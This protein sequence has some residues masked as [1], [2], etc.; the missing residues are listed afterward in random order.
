MP[1]RYEIVQDAEMTKPYLT[2]LNQEESD[3]EK[4]AFISDTIKDTSYASSFSLM[5]RIF[6]SKYLNEIAAQHSPS[7]IA[8]HRESAQKIG[9]IHSRLSPPAEIKTLQDIKHLIFNHEFYRLLMVLAWLL[10]GGL[11]EIF[12]AQLGDMRYFAMPATSK[13]PLIDLLHDVF[14]RV[15]NFQIVNYLLTCCVAY[16]VIGFA[17]QSPDWSTRF[18]LIRRYTFILG[19]L[20][21]FRGITLLV[22][23]LPSSLVDECKPP[24]T[25]ITGSVGERFGF[26]YKVVAGSAFGCTDNIFSGHTSVMMSCVLLWRAHSRLRRPFS[27]LLYLIAF[28][29]MLMIIV[30]RFHYTI[31]VLLAIFITY[32]TWNIYLQYIREA[33]TRYIFGF[34]KHAAFDVFNTM[35]V[36]GAQTY[37]YLAWQPHALGQDWLMHLCMYVD[38][39]DIKLRTIGVLDEQG[40]WRP[41]MNQ[42]SLTKSI[43]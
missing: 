27:W 25:E 41:M 26:I 7:A 32:T 40:E 33:S 31:D 6:Y 16:T 8:Q 39:L 21:I 22:T 13:H 12:L 34:T 15:E 35:M 10:L 30:S 36:D 9:W 42:P 1:Q 24:E 19:C 37:Q 18:T 20:Y 4:H 11:I 38:G 5:H 28:T 17:I 43:V 3:P 29:G 14:P 2:P 23:T